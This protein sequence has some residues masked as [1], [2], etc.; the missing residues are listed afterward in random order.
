MKLAVRLSLLLVIGC[1]ADSNRVLTTPSIATRPAK[2]DVV[3]ADPQPDGE[4]RWSA[5]FFSVEPSAMITI[6]GITPAKGVGVYAVVERSDID[7]WISQGTGEGKLDGEPVTQ[8]AS[9]GESATLSSLVSQW[10]YV[11]GYELKRTESSATWDPSIGVINT[12]TALET[13]A[14]ALTDGRIRATVKFVSTT[15]HGFVNIPVLHYTDNEGEDRVVEAELPLTAEQA[16]EAEVV[17]DSSTC[18]VFIMSP[19]P[20]MWWKEE[21]LRLIELR[22]DPIP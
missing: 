19:P 13:S 15:L 12:A 5:R 20:S 3:R 16:G 4:V 22:C 1:A 2:P 10:S 8:R 18:V 17:L 7:P 9:F 14:L 6:N 11:A 21:T